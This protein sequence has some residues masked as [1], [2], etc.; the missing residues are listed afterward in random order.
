MSRG[1]I[2]RKYPGEWILVGD[3]ISDKHLKLLRGRV[4]FHSKSRDEMYRRAVAL[5]LPEFA[6]LYT[7]EPAKDQEFVL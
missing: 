7:G 2:W 4:V 6:T 5:R 3:P 1:A